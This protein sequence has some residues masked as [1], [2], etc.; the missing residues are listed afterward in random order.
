ME[1]LT[2][3]TPEMVRKEI[4]THLL[5]YNLL[6]SVMEKTAPLLDYQRSKLSF[7]GTRQLFSQMLPLLAT[8]TQVIRQRLYAHLLPRDAQCVHKSRLKGL[9]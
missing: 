1:M 6:R 3:K 8:T 4:W 9:L 5:T 7:Q 2:A